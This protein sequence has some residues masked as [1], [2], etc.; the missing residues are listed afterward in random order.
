M[1]ISNPAEYRGRMEFVEWGTNADGRR[2]ADIRLDGREVG[3]VVLDD[4][5][6]VPALAVAAGAPLS[7]REA[8]ARLVW[9]E[10]ASAGHRQQ[11]MAETVGI[12]P[13]HLSQIVNGRVGANPDIVDRILAACGRR[14][15]LATEPITEKEE[16]TS[17]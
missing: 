7:S 15:V 14:L 8:L 6:A 16:T 13:K 12:T 9:A 11:D 5:D 3:Y 2:V 10:I 17:A 4:P 1:T